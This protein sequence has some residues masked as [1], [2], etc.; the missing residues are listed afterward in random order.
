MM[1]IR[2]RLYIAPGSILMFDDEP[3]KRYLVKSC[4]N[5][6]LLGGIGYQINYIPR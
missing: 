4:I 3:N 2:S 1:K 6:E 5:L